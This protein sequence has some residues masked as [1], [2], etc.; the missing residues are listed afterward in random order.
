MP[1]LAPGFVLPIQ[2]L[3]DYEAAI[4]GWA[5]MKRTRAPVLFE[6]AS[7]F[8]SIL[9]ENYAFAQALELSNRQAHHR[10]REL[11]TIYEIGQAIDPSDVRPLLNMIVGEG[12]ERDGGPDLLSDASARRRPGAGDRSELR[13]QR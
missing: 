9:V 5:P 2:A 4:V 10:M 8:I 12:R 13:S 1:T 6:M 11:A 3:G 7:S